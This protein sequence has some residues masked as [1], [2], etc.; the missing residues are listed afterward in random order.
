[1]EMLE[2]TLKDVEFNCATE[3]LGLEAKVE[4]L[5][6]TVNI[7]ESRIKKLTEQ[8]NKLNNLTGFFAFLAAFWVFIFVCVHTKRIDSVVVLMYLLLSVFGVIVT[9]LLR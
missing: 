1:M 5:E 7:F 9:E 2:Q 8:R 6:E 4:H 3:V